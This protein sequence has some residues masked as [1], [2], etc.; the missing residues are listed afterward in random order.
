MVDEGTTPRR[1]ERQDALENRRQILEAA[2][3]L[4]AEQGI[5]NTSMHEIARAAGVGQGTL[6]RRFAHKGE[7][8]HALLEKDLEEFTERIDAAL[9]G[10]NAPASALSRLNVLITEKIWLTDQHVP[11]LAAIDEAAS[12]TRRFMFFRSS[13]HIWLH[14]KLA[15]LMREAIAKDEVAEM[16]VEFTADAILAVT[17]P[18]VISHQRQCLGFSLD[19]ITKAT[20]ELFVSRP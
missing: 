4:F 1:K 17:S 14:A 16:D 10:A 15:L 5:D 12:G 20:L 9:E 11:L 19:R 8:C 18:M 6:Y 7:L 2:K 13:F 3:R